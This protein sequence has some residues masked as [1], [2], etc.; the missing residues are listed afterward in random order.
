MVLRLFVVSRWE[1]YLEYCLKMKL[2]FLVTLAIGSRD[3][4]EGSHLL[5][6]CGK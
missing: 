4:L 3:G 5:I 1:P 6:A 2:L